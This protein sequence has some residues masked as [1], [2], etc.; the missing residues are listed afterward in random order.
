MHRTTHVIAFVSIVQAPR[1]LVRLTSPMKRGRA[2]LLFAIL[3]LMVAG[4]A[5]WCGRLFYLPPKLVFPSDM[6]ASFQQMARDWHQ[7]NHLPKP[8]PWNWQRFGAELRYPFRDPARP[9][10]RVASLSDGDLLMFVCNHDNL[11]YGIEGPLDE[12]RIIETIIRSTR[13]GLDTD[14][15]VEVEVQV[16][17]H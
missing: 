15:E 17:R 5:A 2:R 6:P 9:T 8:E 16:I 10:L 13:S 1:Q 4:Y 14:P 7:A 3:T 11:V 12:S